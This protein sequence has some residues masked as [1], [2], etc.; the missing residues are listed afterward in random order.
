VTD[1]Q[2]LSR[3]PRVSR[4]DLTRTLDKLADAL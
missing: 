2:L 1:E 3:M 4:A